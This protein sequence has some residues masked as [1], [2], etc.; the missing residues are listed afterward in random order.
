[1]T[2]LKSKGPVEYLTRPDI[3]LSGDEFT[4]IKKYYDEVDAIVDQVN[5]NVEEIANMREELKR[6]AA[7]AQ[8]AQT[9]ATAP[10]K[11]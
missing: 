6:V 11:K 3:D 8:A 10:V 1:M 4:A 5:I 9:A 7:T 2:Q